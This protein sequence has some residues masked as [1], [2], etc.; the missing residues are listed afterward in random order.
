MKRKTITDV[1][2]RPVFFSTHRI[3]VDLL[4]DNGFMVAKLEPEDDRINITVLPAEQAADPKMKMAILD[5]GYDYWG[6]SHDTL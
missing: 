1:R 4:E 5:A 3:L 6:A 2:K